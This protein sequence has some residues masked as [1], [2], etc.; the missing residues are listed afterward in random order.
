[1]TVEIKGVGKVTGSKDVIA[2]LESAFWASGEFLG[3]REC[4][5]LSELHKEVARDMHKE[6]TTQGYYGA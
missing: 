5:H 2:F 4:K 1:M 3:T 6:L